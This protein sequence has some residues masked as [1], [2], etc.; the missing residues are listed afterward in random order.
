MKPV[1]GTEAASMR[2]LKKLPVTVRGALR[3]AE[4]FGDALVCVRHRVDDSGS[5]R[6]TT[7]ELLISKTPIHARQEN[8]VY[9]RIGARELGLQDLARRVGA[10]WDG[11]QRLWLMPKR[12]A[13]LLKLQARIVAK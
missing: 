6:Y 13:N 7:V 5:F 10:Q 3:L 8:R 12:L 1:P 2:V 9:V 11:R 4:Q